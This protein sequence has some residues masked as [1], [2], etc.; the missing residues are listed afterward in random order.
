MRNVGH[1]VN[2]TQIMSNLQGEEVLHNILRN[3]CLVMKMTICIQ[4]IS[5]EATQK[6]QHSVFFT[7]GQLITAKIYRLVGFG[8]V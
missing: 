1:S 7:K 3:K 4:C 6:R 8:L 2:L 5:S